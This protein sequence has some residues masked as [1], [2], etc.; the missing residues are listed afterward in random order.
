MPRK[1]SN[2][3]SVTTIEVRVRY[4]ECDS[5]GVAHHSVYPIWLEMA[6]TEALRAHG[7]AYRDIEAQGVLFVVAR[8]SL[9]YRRPARYDE[10]IR[11]VVK[12]LPTAGVKVDHEYEIFRG[13]ELLTTAE[14]TLVCIDR[15]GNLK[16][17]PPG[18]VG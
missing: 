4:S 1:E 18:M 5:G 14:T 16:P 11:V 3:I 9:R 17:I 12:T 7:V 13:E 8:L 2:P 6:R 10:V 15:Q